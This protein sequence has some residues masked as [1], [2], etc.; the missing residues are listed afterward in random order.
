MGCT[1]AVTPY[2]ARQ[3]G[4]FRRRD[5]LAVAYSVMVW[6]APATFWIYVASI[7]Y[8]LPQY[9]DSVQVLLYFLASLPFSIVIRSRI[10][11]SATAM[12]KEVDLLRFAFPSLI[13]TAIIILL[14][15]QINPTESGV[16]IGWMV[17]IVLTGILGEIFSTRRFSA[18]GTSFDYSLTY[19][20]I[21]ATVV[22]LLCAANP[23]YLSS[24]L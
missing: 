9:S 11:A 7:H 20:S 24:I 2:I 17:A 10:V 1:S 4:A 3:G 8:L 6:V 22:F 18:P 13:V 19:N 23:G 14:A 12:G 21:G 16:A 5:A 15:Y